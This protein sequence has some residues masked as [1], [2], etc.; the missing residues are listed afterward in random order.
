MG[1]LRN[2]R[3]ETDLDFALRYRWDQVTTAVCTSLCRNLLSLLITST[4]A[5]NYQYSRY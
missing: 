5:I 1:D 2:G 3:E 4:L